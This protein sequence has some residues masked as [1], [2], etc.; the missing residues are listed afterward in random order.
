MPCVAVYAPTEMCEA[1]EM[2]YAKLDSILHHCPCQ[3]TL[4]VLGYFN[5]ATGI[6]RD[7][8][9]LCVGP[10]GSGTKSTNSCLLLSYTKSR[11]LIILGSWCQKPE[12]HRWTWYSNAGGL[13]KETDDILNSTRKPSETLIEFYFRIEGF[14][15]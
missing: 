5:A 3:N 4:N 7:S 14:I 13:T 9:E 1:H 2:F 15:E 11:R 8:Y 10:H 12:L 6:A